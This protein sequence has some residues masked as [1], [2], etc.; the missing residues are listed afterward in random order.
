MRAFLPKI[1]LL[2]FFIVVFVQ[3]GLA[4]SIGGELKTEFFYE[5]EKSEVTQSQL[6]FCLDLKKEFGWDKM[7]Y[8]D[9][10]GYYNQDGT[11]DIYLGEAFASFYFDDVDLT[12]GRQ[13]INWGTADGVNPTSYINPIRTNFLPL[14]IPKREALLAA[15][16]TYYGDYWFLTGIFVPFF[17]PQSFDESMR[18]LVGD[19][20]KIDMLINAVDATPL[21]QRS[22][23][24]AEYALRAETFLA[25]WDVQFSYYHGYAHLPA[26]K[27][28]IT[29]DPISMFPTGYELVGKYRKEHKLG[30]ATAGAIQ[31]VGAWGE[32]TYNRPDKL[33]EESDNPF[34]LIEVLSFNKPY[35]QA[36]LGA[37]YTL[38]IGRGL[39][40]QGQ[41]IYL[42]DGSLF[43]PYQ[44]ATD[45]LNGRISYDFDARNTL[46]VIGL[47]NITEGNLVTITTFTHRLIRSVEFQLAWLSSYG[48]G[49]L[50][51]I[52]EQLMAA[53]T[54][55]F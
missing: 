32:V 34:E 52:P 6:S 29:I 1:L 46:D 48:E 4:F 27:S 33:G 13:V 50:P 38:G 42:Q 16:A 45:Y 19:N 23:S 8:L 49:E 11:G 14:G 18:D 44:E 40:V 5:L 55:R 21:P 26:M 31:Q 20:Q 7:I 10:D 15:Q 22:F 51:Y 54:I 24:N 25:G 30:I 35:L 37:D 28:I 3:D 17:V 47:A 43:S 36:V 12:V 39:Y 53:I 9:L 41:Y 2:L